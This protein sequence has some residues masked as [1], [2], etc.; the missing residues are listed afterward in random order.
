MLTIPAGVR[1]DTRF[2]ANNAIYHVIIAPHHKFKRANDDL[3][4]DVEITAIEAML[5]IEVQLDHLDGS[6]LQFAIPAGIQTGQI[7]RLGAKGMKNPETD[8]Y[9]DLMNR[10]TVTTPR[11]LT[12]EQKVFLRT[13]QPRNMLSI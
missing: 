5:G 2:L 13:M 6:K 4:V 12:E 9:G 3:L 7:V 1:P 10:I 8:R 11:N